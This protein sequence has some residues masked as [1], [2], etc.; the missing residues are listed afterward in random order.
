MPVKIAAVHHGLASFRLTNT[1]LLTYDQTNADLPSD[2]R[3][4]SQWQLIVTLGVPARNSEN[5]PCK[6][7]MLV[8]RASR[9]IVHSSEKCYTYIF[10]SGSVAR[11]VFLNLTKKTCYASA[12]CSR[13]LTQKTNNNTFLNLTHLFG[14]T[15]ST[16]KLEPAANAGDL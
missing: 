15:Q 9:I 8:S 4:T 16:K 14:E 13:T 12:L 10:C 11:A 2:I 3:A 1:I 7:E 6:R 5:V